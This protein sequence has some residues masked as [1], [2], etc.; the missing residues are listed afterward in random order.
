VRL[1]IDMQG[2]QAQSRE[3]G[4]GRYTRAFVHGLIRQN[5]THQIILVLNGQFP[6]TLRSLREAFEDWLPPGSIKVWQAPGPVQQVDDNNQARRNM[7][8]MLYESFLASLRP[9]WVLVTS[10]FEG[11]GDNALTS[12]RRHCPDLPVASILFDLIPLIYPERYLSSPAHY[13]WYHEKLKHLARSQLLLAISESSREEAIEHLAWPEQAVI[14][15]SSAAEH[16]FQPLKISE[17]RRQ[18]LRKHYGLHRSFVM[19]TGG[20]DFRKNIEALIQAFA[21]LPEPLRARHQLAI[22]CSISQEE[23]ARLRRL[24]QEH[25]LTKS[26]LALTGYIPEHD[27]VELYNLCQLFVFPSRHEGFGLPALEAMSCGAPVIASNFSSLPEVVG[28][29]EALFD[30]NDYLSIRDAIERGLSDERYR[31][32]LKEH[33][34]AQSQK[35]SWD[36]TAKVALQALEAQV[37]A[38]EAAYVR[39]KPGPGPSLAVVSPLPPQKSGISDYTVELVQQLQLNGWY[40]ITLVCNEANPC[41]PDSLSN[42]RV[43][44]PERFLEISH[45]FAR[46][47]YHFGNS[48]FHSY[49]FALLRDVP[50]V[51]VLHDFYLSGVLAWNESFGEGDGSWYQALQHSHGYA[52]LAELT[53]GR[54]PADVIR[55]YPA[56][57]EVIQQALAVIVHSP[58]SQRL[59]NKWYGESVSECMRHIPLL[60]QAAF[61][62]A[63]DKEQARR[64]LGIGSDELVVCSF[65]VLGPTKLNHRLAAAWAKS[66]A[67]ARISNKRLVF[68]GGPKGSPYSHALEQQEARSAKPVNLTVTDWVDRE[69][70]QNYLKAAD[71]AVQLRTDSRGET[72]A[73]VLDCLNYGLATIV[74]ANGSMADLPNNVVYKLPDEFSDEHLTNALEALVFSE[75]KRGTLV[76]CGQQ[77][78]RSHHDPQRCAEAYRNIL[79]RAYSSL[80]MK[81]G[82]IVNGLALRLPK[83]SVELSKLDLNQLARSIDWNFPPSPRP[84]KVMVD[85][86]AC[87]ESDGAQP[88]SSAFLSVVLKECSGKVRIEP[89]RYDD[90]ASAYRLA[91][92]WGYSLLGGG[93]TFASD[94]IADFFPGDLLLD[95]DLPEPHRKKLSTVHESL[96]DL[97]IET[98]SWNEK[99]EVCDEAALA[100]ELAR[101]V[102]GKNTGNTKSLYVDISELAKQDRGTGV[103]RVVKQIL[104]HWME[105][106]PAGYIV[107]PVYT[108]PGAPGYFHADHWW[109]QQYYPG[110]K[111]SPSL[112]VHYRKG[113]YFVGLDLNPL[114]AVVNRFEYQSM[115]EQGVTTWFVVYDLIPV[116]SP[117]Y[118]LPGA[119]EVYTQWLEVA[120][121]ADGIAC[122]SRAV[123]DELTEWCSQN[124]I[125][126]QMPKLTWFHLGADFDTKKDWPS[127]AQCLPLEIMDSGAPVFLMVG[128]LEPRKGHEQVLDAFD[129]L[130]ESGEQ[131]RLVIVGKQGWLVDQLVER[132]RFHREYGKRLFW[133][134]NVT[135]DQLPAI[136][137]NSHAVVAAS[138]NEG[139]GLPLIEAAHYGVPLIVRDI[140]VFREVA[141]ENAFYVSGHTVEAFATTISQWLREQ[142]VGGAPAANN[143]TWF[144]WEKSAEQLAGRIG[145]PVSNSSVGDF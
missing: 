70:Y 46:V 38:K 86:T 53:N 51:V 91:R 34:L 109:L 66:S 39:S 127:P 88:L 138:Y 68:V 116:R 123:R 22:V 73:S 105:S 9:D 99:P 55:D 140:P 23:R 112:P 110:L 57:L 135:D 131:C 89:V 14:N 90:T 133:L 75:E 65:G 37:A 83:S 5:K 145:L 125:T 49:M 82:Q 43:I 8:E 18:V 139:F 81:A 114:G 104:R 80:A 4:I 118:F 27:L 124:L 63:A 25:G 7:G 78:V 94:D 19:Y 40:Q 32:T 50:G 31:Q 77:H 103:Q 2:A 36:K 141:G 1:I 21:A 136:Y 85:V 64:A 48:E 137:R 122:I 121:E 60:R 52:P 20:I 54:E 143:L 100:K 106:P 35:F 130:W 87:E 56:N 74:N 117:E 71:I 13:H 61:Q 10:V 126:Q 16:H 58:V 11:L 119:K 102:F 96:R 45:E 142:Q 144:S 3:R 62:E 108:R 29:P 12:I 67:L 69:T 84:S 33:G 26:E 59:A 95:L 93:Q 111:L 24:A 28:L 76:K 134:T 107:R 42:L 128:T 132:I 101:F 30:P 120:T 98:C 47:L 79:E 15:V 6:E 113:D 92:H 41:L 44:S 115:R 17:H 129:M 72:S 97:G